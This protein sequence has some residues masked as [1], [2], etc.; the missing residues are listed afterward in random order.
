[1]KLRKY[2]QIQLGILLGLLVSWPMCV[3][4]NLGFVAQQSDCKINCLNGGVC[5]FDIGNP[6]IHKCI[7]FIGLFEGER[8]EF[9][10]QFV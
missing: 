3:Q 7:C 1:M 5:A 10:G 4:A 8:C 9:K 2:A 6:D